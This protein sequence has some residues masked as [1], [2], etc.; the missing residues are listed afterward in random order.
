MIEPLQDLPSDEALEAEGATPALARFLLEIPYPELHLL[1]K[2][3][4]G[5]PTDSDSHP[6]ERAKAAT[7]YRML[8]RELERRLRQAVWPA[9]EETDLPF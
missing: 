6:D 4:G 1:Y 8:G 7:M 9:G 5:F 3:L 2:A